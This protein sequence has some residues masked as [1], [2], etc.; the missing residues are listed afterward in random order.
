MTRHS[1]SQTTDTNT[2]SSLHTLA[3]RF[4]NRNQRAD[5]NS[6]KLARICRPIWPH[7]RPDWTS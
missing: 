1:F 4:T 5:L 3:E 2:P 6:C 7:S